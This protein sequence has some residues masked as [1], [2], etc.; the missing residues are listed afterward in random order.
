MRVLS[1]VVSPLVRR[2]PVSPCLA[3]F[4]ALTFL[5]GA[6]RSPA[7]VAVVFTAVH[8]GGV[9]SARSSPRGGRLWTRSCPPTPLSPHNLQA[10]RLVCVTVPA[11]GS[12]NFHLVQC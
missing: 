4:A 2:A 6:F 9:V 11:S 5:F 8:C 3:H 12:R 10:V 7:L 1:F